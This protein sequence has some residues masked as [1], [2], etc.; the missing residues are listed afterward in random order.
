MAI[1]FDSTKH[2][3]IRD[4]HV[5]LNEKFA[6]DRKWG[7]D[8]VFHFCRQQQVG[9]LH[10]LSPRPQWHGQEIRVITTEDAD[11]LTTL[12]VRDYER[13]KERKDDHEARQK[14]IDDDWKRRLASRNTQ[15]AANARQMV[16]RREI[17]QLEN[18]KHRALAAVREEWPK[19]KQ[20]CA[21]HYREDVDRAMHEC[22]ERYNEGVQA[23]D[24]EIQAQVDQIED[25]YAEKIAAVDQEQ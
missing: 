5:S 9:L 17:D 16:A 21:T 3:S 22:L 4:F 18:Q 12:F 13:W 8:W 1:S 15:E 7:L 2:V 10:V 19:R 24:E 20:D 23:L 11:R 14:K 25:E 6:D